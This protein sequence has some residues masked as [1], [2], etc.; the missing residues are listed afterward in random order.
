MGGLFLDS[1]LVVDIMIIC[2]FVKGR[3]GRD[4]FGE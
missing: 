2:G 3:E 1:N 4:V